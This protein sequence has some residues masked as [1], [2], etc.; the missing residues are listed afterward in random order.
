VGSIPANSDALNV[1]SFRRWRF[2][3]KP[4]PL[5]LTNKHPLYGNRCESA[6]GITGTSHVLKEAGAFAPDLRCANRDRPMCRCIL[7]IGTW[8]RAMMI[9]SVVSAVSRPSLKSDS[10][11]QRWQGI[12][13]SVYHAQ[14]NFFHRPSVCNGAHAEWRAR[15]GSIRPCIHVISGRDK[16]TT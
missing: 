7:S 16:I 6:L 3:M 8:N 11:Y 4:C 15:I 12:S 1:P 14:I 5:F 10:S 9:R 13:L 2:E